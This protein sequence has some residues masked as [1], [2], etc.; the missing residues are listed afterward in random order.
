MNEQAN[1]LLVQQAYQL[2]AKREMS[3]LLN[4]L[5]ADVQW[6]LPEMDH[7]PFAGQWQGQEGVGQF[8]RTVAEVQ[9]PVEFEPQ[10]FIAQCGAD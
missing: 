9:E 7:V 10:G 6:Q 1:T 3:S 8:F 2:I 4:L 5:A